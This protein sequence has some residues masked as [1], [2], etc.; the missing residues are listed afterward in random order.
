M[1][2][3]PGFNAAAF[4]Y[5]NPEVAAAVSGPEAVVAAWDAN[6]AAWGALPA[7]LPPLP[8][9][10]EPRVFLA[11]CPDVSGLNAAVRAA[12]ARET[13]LTAA[14][15]DAQAPFVATLGS[16]PVRLVAP[17]AFELATAPGALALSDSNLRVGD[18]LRL[19]RPRLGH[20]DGTVV[21]VAPPSGFALSNPLS[22]LADPGPY[23][24]FGIRVADPVRQALAALA[25]S[26]ALI[27]WPAA[28]ASF[29][30]FS[31]NAP[32]AVDGGYEPD[33][34]RT[35]YPDARAMSYEDAYLDHVG[36]W[37]RGEQFR[38]TKGDDLVSRR[39]PLVSFCNLAIG[40]TLGIGMP[41]PDFAAT[42]AR[43][44]VAGDVFT[45]GT[46]IT[47]SDARVKAGLAPI[48]RPLERVARLT[49]YTYA[50]A[51][52]AAS[53]GP[54]GPRR[55]AGL[56]AQDVLR[57][58]PEAVYGERG[59]R[60]AEGD[61]AAPEPLRSVAYGNLAGLFAEAIKELAGRLEAH[62]RRCAADHADREPS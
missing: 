39:A 61:A 29:D 8:A 51:A 14:Q 3:P 22:A 53:G 24:A 6:A 11:T 30:A 10:F 54:E 34:Y 20:V 49:G 19:L 52:E 2:P 60:A 5:L 56:L 4:L 46:V 41:N 25:R 35:L 7:A 37:T 16:A 13:G 40:D 26:N 44:A 38:A 47:Q 55:H 21:A 1:P 36:R 42:G 31:S 48:D 43:L 17:G 50:L 33:T 32:A 12:V 18:R 27:A 9:G 59:E 15:V 58:L 28:P 57:A 23:A 45:T 62:D